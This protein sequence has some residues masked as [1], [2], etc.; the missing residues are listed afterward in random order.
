MSGSSTTGG[1]C[2]WCCRGEGSSHPGLSPG[3]VFSIATRGGAEAW[4]INSEMGT[5]EPE[6]LARI[7]AVDCQESMNSTE[8][9]LEYLTTVGESVQVEWVE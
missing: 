4:G 2:P 1:C 5:L 7:M 3:T 6:K 8:D 9:V